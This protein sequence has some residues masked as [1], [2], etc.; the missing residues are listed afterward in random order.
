MRFG[1]ISK[2]PRVPIVAESIPAELKPYPQ[3][4]LWRWE[5]RDGKWTK[6]PYQP[7]G[8]YAMSTD[9]TTWAS[10]DGV[11]SAMQTEQFDGIG[12][13]LTAADP[14]TAFDWDHCRDS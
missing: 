9:S 2:P 5:W 8:A 6:P 3:W 11:L 1:T 12:F 7:S 10:F 13:V 4:V 14:Y